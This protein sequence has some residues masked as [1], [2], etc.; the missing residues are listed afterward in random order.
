MRRKNLIKKAVFLLLVLSGII[1]VSWLSTARVFDVYELTLLDLRFRVRP[2][3]EISKDVVIIEIS[4]DSIKAAGS[5]P[6]DRSYHETLIK[7]LSYAGVSQIVFDIFFSE[8]KDE[9]VAFI[10]AVKDAGNVYMPYIFVLKDGGIDGNM[11][12]SEKYDSA[13]IDG[14]E[15][16]SRGTGHINIVPDIDGKFRRLPLL[17]KYGDKLYPHVSFHAWLNRTGMETDSIRLIPG[18]E[19]ALAAA[20]EMI[21]L[22]DTSNMIINVPGRWEHTFR[23]YSYTDVIASYIDILTGEKPRIDLKGLNGTICF[24]GISATAA[25]DLHPSPY[26][27]LYPGVGMHA[28]MVN[29]LIT[30]KFITRVSRALNLVILLFLVVA[31]S[32]FALKARK[33]KSIIYTLMTL[34][35]FIGTAFAVFAVFGL[36]IDIFYP[37]ILTSVL[38]LWLT[39]VR[40]IAELRKRE[41]LE[42]ELDIAKN[43]QRSFLPKEYPALQGMEMYANMLTARQVGGDLYSFVEFGPK[44][45]GIMIGDVSGKGVPAALYMAKAVSEFKTYALG[46]LSP[47]VTMT[48]LNNRLSSDSGANLFVTVAYVIADTES[49]MVKFSMGGHL[50]IILRRAATNEV[51]LLDRPDGMPLGLMECEFSDGETRLAKG[52]MLV[53]YTDGVT[54]AMNASH[55]MFEQAKL[56]DII[57]K[58]PEAGPKETVENILNAVSK[59]EGKGRQHDDITVIAFRI[60]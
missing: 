55:E 56:A 42:K 41:L 30:G 60:V 43:I 37:V 50:P 23:H 34:L 10:Q 16:A 22:D 38:Y 13:L 54:E 44:T 1:L 45:L 49:G 3:P 24:V 14:L 58:H 19:I 20:P 28:S 33:S 53:F 59:F 7:A 9:D 52:D 40:Y 11:V 35:I 57:K 39:F 36:W 27:P 17:I 15:E 5:W 48:A 4:D 21:P 32:V 18:R 2:Q 25:S 12:H 51:E 29:S 6:F 47:A 8:P 46:S 31:V 26:E